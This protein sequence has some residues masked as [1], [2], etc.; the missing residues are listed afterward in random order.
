MPSSSSS[1][2]F[3]FRLRRILKPASKFFYRE[4]GDGNQLSSQSPPSPYETA[5]PA[6]ESTAQHEYQQIELNPYDTV[7]SSASPELIELGPYD[8]IL[9]RDSSGFIEL[10]PYD[11]ILS[12]SSIAQ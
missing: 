4:V 6:G 11:T 8:T 7:L 1:S 12:S 2:C 9:S 5:L 10:D 3:C